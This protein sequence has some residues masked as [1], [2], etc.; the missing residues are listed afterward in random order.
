MLPINLNKYTH[1]VWDFNG[2]ILNDVGIGIDSVNCLL[3]KRKLPV[4]DSVEKY[5]SLFGF[6]IKEYYRRLGFDFT[7]ESY[8]IVA[9]EWI[10]EYNSRRLNAPLC[11]GSKKLIQK[12]AKLGITQLIISATEYNMLVSQLEELGVR[13]YF[14]ELLGLDDIKA[15]SKVHL[16]VSWKDAHPH[17]KV[18]FIGDTDHDLEVATAMKA[19][20]LLVANGHQSYEYL[21]AFGVPLVKSLEDV[22]LVD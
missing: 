11:P 14:T 19:D 7:K 21:S 6:P 17:A 10:N 1:I 2:T 5:H 9:M 8:D 15:G 3:R 12:F 20:C 4:I 16:A 18:L 13:E 22:R